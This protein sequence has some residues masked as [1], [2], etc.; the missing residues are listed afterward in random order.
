MPGYDGT[1]PRGR[2]PMTGWGSGFCG[3]TT[4]E[5]EKLKKEHPEDYPNED[6]PPRQ[7]FGWGRGFGRGRGMQ[8]R[9]GRGQGRGFGWGRRHR[10]RGGWNRW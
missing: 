4:E 8:W 3:M 6:Y 7:G 9:H 2:G 1:G 5:Y 10:H